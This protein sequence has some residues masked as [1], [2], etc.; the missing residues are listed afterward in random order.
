MNPNNIEVFYMDCAKLINL[1][2]Y[3]RNL[4]ACDQR[5]KELLIKK[6]SWGKLYVKIIIFQVETDIYFLS[7]V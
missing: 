3:A 2:N 6:F 7:E 1:I 4:K 5:L